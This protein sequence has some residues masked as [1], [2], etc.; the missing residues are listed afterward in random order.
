[1]VLRGSATPANMKLYS[2]IFTFLLFLILKLPGIWERVGFDRPA[3]GGVGQTATGL[4][5]IVIGMAVISTSLWVGDTHVYEGVNWTHVLKGFL[6][7]SGLASIGMG[8][9]TLLAPAL[10]R[11]LMRTSEQPR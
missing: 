1:M 8:M 10:R 5:A 7:G 2:N 3:G 11:R 4:T 9:L 6:A